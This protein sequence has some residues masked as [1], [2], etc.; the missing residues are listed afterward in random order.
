MPRKPLPPLT[1][2]RAFEA[3][4]RNL[5]F[6]RAADELNISQSAISH[7]IANLETVLNV[8][9]FRRLARRVELTE[10]GILY[11]PYLRDAFDRIEQGTA[12]IGRTSAAGDLTVQIYVT[13]AARWL[14]PRLERFRERH[15]NIQVRL[16]TSHLD[17]EF[18]VDAADV[19]IIYT[20]DPDRARLHYEHLFDAKIFPVCSPAFLAGAGDLAHAPDLNAFPLLQLYTAAD[21]W[22]V[23]LA[24]AGRPTLGDKPGPKFDNYLLALEAAIDGQGLAVVPHFMVA[25]DLKSGRLV[26]P[27]EVEAKQSGH[28]YLACRK[29]RAD[30]PRILRFRDWL[31]DEIAV[32]T[33]MA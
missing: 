8:R 23:W 29:E 15:P 10:P 3:A 18:D 13:V 20:R 12:L 28:W 16:S 19:G 6:H 24:A 30:E 4:A 7:Q 9:L 17:W 25:N 2:L 31:V 21:D 14:I 27:F 32:D 11:Y 1:A 5:S 26:R 33:T 22:T